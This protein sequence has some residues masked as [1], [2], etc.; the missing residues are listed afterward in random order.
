MDKI[1]PEP[2]VIVSLT[3]FPAAI[4]YAVEAVKSILAGSVLP[5]KIVLYL[6]PSE[7]GNRPLPQK[8]LELAAENPIFEIRNYDREIR[9]YMKL[10]PALQ[11]FPDAAIVTIDDDV[12]YK[13]RMLERL[14]KY[15]KAHPERIIAHRVRRIALGK[16]YTKWRKYHWNNFIL[17]R[18]YSGFGNLLTGVGGVLYPPGSLKKD[19]M[20][21]ELF[22]K[23]APTADDIWFWAAAVANNKKI[24][25]IPFGYI[26]QKDLGKPEKISLKIN[27]I[28]S[29]VDRNGIA[30]EAIFANYPEIR[31]KVENERRQ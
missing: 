11:D 5:D 13:K 25:P 22:T 1:K 19:M 24:M 6:T 21:E 16:P 9:S 18:D 27:N 3:S 23:L 15:H 29:G 12:Y 10:I 31:E 8:L 2:K 4:E 30:L 17:K 26:H 20:K 14:L 7:F 28:K